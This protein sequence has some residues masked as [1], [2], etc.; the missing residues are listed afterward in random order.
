M[1]VVCA[2]C[3]KLGLPSFQHEK[4]PYEDTRISHGMCPTHEEEWRVQASE[5]KARRLAAA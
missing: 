3:A 1:I 5:L 2:W 4:E